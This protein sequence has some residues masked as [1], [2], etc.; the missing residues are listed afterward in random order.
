LAYALIVLVLT[1]LVVA[2]IFLQPV[3]VQRRRQRVSQPPLPSQWRAIL[4]QRVAPYHQLQPEQRR[5][6]QR[7]IQVFLAEK[8]FI[9][10]NGL[11]VSEEM[12]VT[13]AAIA[14]LLLL[15]DHSNYFPK[16]RTI[17]LYP[18]SY[19]ATETVSPDGLIVQ[20]RRVSRLGE[21]WSRDQLVLAWDQVEH[22]TRH[23]QD[24]QNVVLHEFAHQ[25]DQ[26]EGSA[27]G[28]PYLPASITAADWSQ[29]MTRTYQHLCQA[30]EHNR[31]HVINSYGAT[32]PAEFF[33]V[34]TET[35]IEN[36]QAL[37]SSHPDLYTLF[38][39]Y[40]QLDP[41]QWQ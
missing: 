29:V 5:S 22:D 24:G 4:E 32:N 39:H 16:L 19:W 11:K 40:Y 34:V 1:G 25:L 20:E 18:S 41:C 35:F 17:L 9:G 31:R 6:L 13:I 27:N 23:W 38:K 33:A 2:A 26:A 10:C 15:N 36:P 3:I 8:Q 30:V 14:S 28:V 21:S 7:R 12:Q 37:Q